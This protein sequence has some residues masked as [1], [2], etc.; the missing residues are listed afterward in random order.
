LNRL[1]T[2]GLSSPCGAV[3]EEASGRAPAPWFP[4]RY[5]SV[6]LP[7][8]APTED[9]KRCPS[10]IAVGL[11]RGDGPADGS[12][13]VATTLPE[14]LDRS[15]DA[16]LVLDT[17]L[18]EAFHTSAGAL[19]DL[20]PA[21]ESTVIVLVSRRPP[22]VTQFR[23]DGPVFSFLCSPAVL[24]Q[25]LTHSPDAAARDLC[26]EVLHQILNGSIEPLDRLMVRQIPAE[27]ST[28]VQA[29]LD[30]PATVIMAHR[31]PQHYLGT[32]LH[33]LSKAERSAGLQVRVGLDVDTPDDYRP[34]AECHPTA[35][36]F[37]VTPAPVGPYVIRQELAA[38]SQEPLLTLQDS[39]DLSCYDR[40]ATLALKIA[41]GECDMVG[42]HELRVD[43]IERH[44]VAVRF[45]LDATAA[46]RERNCFAL[47][48]ATLMIRRSAFFA[49][50]GLSTDQLV[51]NDTQFLMRAFFY[52]RICNA[53][54]FLYVRRRH[55][56]SLT[57]APETAAGNELRTRLDNQWTEDFEAVKRGELAL[58]ES[59]LRPMR[60]TSAYR[61]EPV[62]RSSTA[63]GQVSSSTLENVGPA[64]SFSGR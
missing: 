7:V 21:A 1:G 36:F 61:I 28:G 11:S 34:L 37:G 51:A 2:D 63:N 42:S 41:G 29:H 6:P 5:L 16:V 60:A 58:E 49:A 47:L 30:L 57:I 24:K 55:R 39:D 4:I 10:L 52:H 32:A 56:R 17:M 62:F 48:H 64:S 50:G 59:S 40:F 13:D 14:L 23:S 25:A 45:P 46:L 54:E 35:E 22:P 27:P 12:G 26:F 9:G 8:S 33:Y 38:R 53:D 18:W 20:M 44:V 3:A 15:M 43:E 31:G 19:L